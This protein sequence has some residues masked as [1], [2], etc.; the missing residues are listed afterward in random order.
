MFLLWISKKKRP[1]LRSGCA[2]SLHDEDFHDDSTIEG[3]LVV[4]D[5]MFSSLPALLIFFD[6]LNDKCFSTNEAFFLRITL[7]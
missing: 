4:H 3:I 2:G 5:V 6:T 7:L 1:M